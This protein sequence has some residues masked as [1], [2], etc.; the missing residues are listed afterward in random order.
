MSNLDN[1]ISKIIGDCEEKSKQITDSANERAS[2][3]MREN[4]E[5]AEKEKDKILSGAKAEAKIMA[6]QIVLSKNLEMRDANL[7]AKR[8]IIDR[9]FDRALQKL[10]E[11]PK[12]VFID[13]LRKSLA[14]LDLDGEEIV[15]PSKYEITDIEEIN[16]F[17]KE[18]NKKGNLKLYKGDKKI[19]GGFVLLKE[20]IENNN[21]FETLIKY[22]RYELE[23]EIIAKLF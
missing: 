6:E 8:E 22:Y 18:K 20:G 10:N 9:V 16:A 11:M 4:I 5:A 2:E 3:I 19:D 1:L 17:L 23:G 21:T 7:N 14:A 13:F 12:N 15:L